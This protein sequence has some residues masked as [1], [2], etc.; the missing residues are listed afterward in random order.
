MTLCHSLRRMT[1]IVK[2]FL[3]PSTPFVNL[4]CLFSPNVNRGKAL[5]LSAHCGINLTDDLDKYLGIPILHRRV[6]HSTYN[7]LMENICKKL[8]GWKSNFLSMAGRVTF[9]KSVTNTIQNIP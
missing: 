7:Y 9:I 6:A 8:A 1:R 3:T 5:G 2:L 4:N